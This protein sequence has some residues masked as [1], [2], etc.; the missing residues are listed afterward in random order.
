MPAITEPKLISG[1]ANLSLAKAI[2][3]LTD[4]WPPPPLALSPVPFEPSEDTLTPAAADRLNDQVWALQRWG[5]ASAEAV[6]FLPTASAAQSFNE[7]SP[8]H[9]RASAVAAEHQA[10]RAEECRELRNKLASIPEGRSYYRK[11][12]DGQRSYYS[13]EQVDTARQQL[14]SRVSERCS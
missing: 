7:N 3:P 11:E 13:D 4:R 5:A 9:V 1:N 14:Q 10:K 2:A 8:G 6:V 12:A